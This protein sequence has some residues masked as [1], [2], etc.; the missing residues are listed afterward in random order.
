MLKL[1]AKY[2][3]Y[4]ILLTDHYHRIVQEI[5]M[6]QK[7]LKE[8]ILREDSDLLIDPYDREVLISR[9]FDR[10]RILHANVMYINLMLERGKD[11]PYIYQIPHLGWY[12]NMDK[13]IVEDIMRKY[14]YLKY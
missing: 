1:T 11:T 14:Q 3:Q 8:E 5:L 9:I 4:A 6:I 13:S 10:V 2:P 7:E 12:V